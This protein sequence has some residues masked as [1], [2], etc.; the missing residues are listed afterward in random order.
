MLK[1]SMKK[2]IFFK[3]IILIILLILLKIIIP[4]ILFIS[5]IDKNPCHYRG[6]Y[7]FLEKFMWS[8]CFYE[9]YDDNF[10]EMT[11][12]YPGPKHFPRWQ[13]YIYKVDRNTGELLEW[14]WVTN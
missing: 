3:I 6:Y 8:E 5:G 13:S 9:I 12:H 10:Y 11:I 4:K 2:K 14:I 7:E 1:V